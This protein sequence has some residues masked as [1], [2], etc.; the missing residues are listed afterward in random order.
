VKYPPLQDLPFH[1]STMRVL[2]DYGNPAYGFQDYFDLSLL[3]TQ[4]LLYYLLGSALAYVLGVVKANV[5]MMS[6]YLGGTPLAIRDLL[7][8]LKKDERLCLLS[9]P[10]L[11][12]V[13]FMFG[14]LPFMFG[15]PIMFWGL[16][17]CVRYFDKP[18]RRRGILLAALTFAVFYSHLFPFGLFAIGYAAMFPWTQPRKWVAAVLPPVPTVC[19]F[20]LWLLTPSGQLVRGAL[21]GETSDVVLPLGQSIH[22]A[23]TWIGD[24]F[25]DTTDELYFVLTIALAVA[26]IGLAQGDKE[27]ARREAKI[28]VALPLLCMLLFFTMGQSR[29]IVWLFA[30]RFPILLLFTLIPLLRMPT[31]W[32]GHAVGATMLALGVASTVNVCKHFVQFQLEEV[33]DLDGAL[34]AMPPRKKT[35]AL[36]FDKYSSTINWAPFLHFGSYYQLEKGGLVEFTYAD[37]VHWPFRFKPDQLPPTRPRGG[38]PPIRARLEWVP[39]QITIQ[40]LYP[41]FDYVLTRGPGF[42]PPPGTFHRKWRGEKWE[43]WERDGAR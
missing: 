18:T 33:G 25:R 43:V 9:I 4:Y 42:R 27:K 16:A 7:A 10:L 31:G 22:E 28:L 8:A 36:I 5:A 41:Y 6:F 17:T 38:G 39:E 13:M 34:A 11:V 35:A 20:G 19:V 12:N 14:L 15:V 2:H 37:F 30:Q 32:R 29:G 40:E 23:Y 1:L 26:A 24:V 21:K 3:R